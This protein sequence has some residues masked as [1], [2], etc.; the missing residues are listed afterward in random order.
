[1]SV[2]LDRSL[3]LKFLSRISGMLL[4]DNDLCNS[5]NSESN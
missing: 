4:S 3:K 5:G 1:M 2:Y